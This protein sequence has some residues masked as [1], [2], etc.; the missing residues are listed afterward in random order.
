MNQTK[1]IRQ[2]TIDIG[3]W[4]VN[5]YDYLDTVGYG[6]L[7]QMG[8]WARAQLK[9]KQSIRCSP[10]KDRVICIHRIKTRQ[11]IGD[12]LIFLMNWCFIKDIALSLEEAKTYVHTNRRKHDL[13]PVGLIMASI[14]QLFLMHDEQISGDPILRRPYAQRIF[15]NLALL[16]YLMGEEVMF[17]LNYTWQKIEKLNWRKYPTDGKSN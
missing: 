10:D 2:L 6:M 15:N 4:A 1:S 17:T 7:K 12:C 14:S 11:A 13:V 8:R 9:Y 16:C 3:T 5:N